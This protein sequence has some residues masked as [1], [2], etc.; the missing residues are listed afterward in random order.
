MNKMQIMLEAML[1]NSILREEYLQLMG[2]LVPVHS[3][4]DPSSHQ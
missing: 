4:Q 3:L 2:S 1:L